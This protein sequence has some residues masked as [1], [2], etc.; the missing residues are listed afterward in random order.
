MRRQTPEK[1][2]AI[3]HHLYL[4][5]LVMCQSEFRRRYGREMGQVFRDHCREARRQGGLVGLAFWWVRALSDLAGTAVATHVYAFVQG[6]VEMKRILRLTAQGVFGCAGILLFFYTMIKRPMPHW[7]AGVLLCVAIACL[8][9]ALGL[10][11]AT[12]YREN[13]RARK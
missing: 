7:N 6:E 2:V 11:W 5:L 8:S 10:T 4:L 9:V 13:G 3:S 12:A 1:I